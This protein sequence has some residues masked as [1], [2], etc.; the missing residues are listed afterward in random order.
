[1]IIFDSTD[2]WSSSLNDGTAHHPV[3]LSREQIPE[4]AA[5]TSVAADSLGAMTNGVG[6]PPR[7]P[8][9]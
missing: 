6:L 5:I 2:L 4:A 8:P 7:P 3:G 9:S 1:M